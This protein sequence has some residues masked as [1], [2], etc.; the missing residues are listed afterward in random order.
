MAPNI[1]DLEKNAIELLNMIQE[2]KYAPKIIP[3]DL[4]YN[5]IDNLGMA[6]TK[7]AFASQNNKESDN[8]IGKAITSLWKI[9]EYLTLDD[10]TDVRILRLKEIAK[11]TPRKNKG[12]ANVET[13]VGYLEL[14]NRLQKKINETENIEE[15]IEIAS[16]FESSDFK[17][18]D[19]EYK[20]EIFEKIIS[21]KSIIQP[22]DCYVALNSKKEIGYYKFHEFYNL[23]ENVSELRNT[24]ENGIQ[25]Q[26]IEFLKSGL[27][28]VRNY[29]YQNTIS[30]NDIVKIVRGEEIFNSAA[31][32]S[33]YKKLQ[34]NEQDVEA[35]K[36][37]NV[38]II[39]K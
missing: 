16:A 7:L 26:G 24:L 18:L 35:I 1:I 15:L 32:K 3:H 10:D 4:T 31:E 21:K 19:K 6:L 37:G 29:A 13:A 2:I 38:P 25:L 5:D 23:F 36:K 8:I 11:E 20:Y 33:M 22:G 14:L 28:P 34:L 12:K 17:F 30:E 27:L 9:R 39:V